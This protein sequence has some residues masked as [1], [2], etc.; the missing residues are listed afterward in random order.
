[1]NLDRVVEFFLP[2]TGNMFVK[3]D[4]EV[5]EKWRSCLT[6]SYI[7]SG[8]PRRLHVLLKLRF[9]ADLRIAG[10]R[11]TPDVHDTR[12]SQPTYAPS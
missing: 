3:L 7:Y 2:N 1:V 11:P 12:R 9:E 5:D 10:R 4:N 6:E 8:W